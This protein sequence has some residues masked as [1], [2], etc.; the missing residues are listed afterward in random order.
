MLFQMPTV[1]SMFG[2]AQSNLY[3]ARIRDCDICIGWILVCKPHSRIVQRDVEAILCEFL[4]RDECREGN[5]TF[6]FETN[7]F[8]PPGADTY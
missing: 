1:I 2:N 6:F 3:I 4:L 8:S 5:F 7:S